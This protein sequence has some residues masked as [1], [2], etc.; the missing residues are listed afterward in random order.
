MQA[1]R[2]QSGRK[3]FRGDVEAQSHHSDQSA[4]Q[5]GKDLSIFRGR[6]QRLA[7]EWVAFLFS[8]LRGTKVD[9][10]VSSAANGIGCVRSGSAAAT[11]TTKRHHAKDVSAKLAG[12][13]PVLQHCTGAHNDISGTAASWT[14]LMSGSDSAAL[15]QF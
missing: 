8:C 2:P 12:H 14:D 4:H 13:V 11:S 7:G 10:P 9:P 1:E 5:C 15:M 3:T 6:I